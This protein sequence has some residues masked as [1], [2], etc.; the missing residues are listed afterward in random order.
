MQDAMQDALLTTP[1]VFLSLFLSVS[2]LALNLLEL[3]YYPTRVFELVFELVLDLVHSQN[4][5]LLV[6][7]WLF[8][9]SPSQNARPCAR[10]QDANVLLCALPLSCSRSHAPAL[11]LPLYVCLSVLSVLSAR[12]EAMC[13]YLLG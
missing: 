13:V 3:T 9:A 6:V 10:V 11:M 8:V 2:V 1:L 7:Y 4:G 5:C 12:P